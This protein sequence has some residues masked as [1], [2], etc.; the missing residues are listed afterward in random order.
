[1]LIPTLNWLTPSIFASVDNVNL[2]EKNLIIQGTRLD[3]YE[4]PLYLNYN[5]RIL[6]KNQDNNFENGVYL[7]KASFD[8]YSYFIKL[9]NQIGTTVFIQSGDQNK[10]TTWMLISDYEWFQ[11]SSSSYN[12]NLN[13]TLNE[14]LNEI[15]RK[16]EYRSI[17][18][19]WEPQLC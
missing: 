8:D 16:V 9:E 14:N 5:D 3:G 19:K 10:N 18:D 1:M 12:E 11:L 15:K 6:L 2:I 7:F 4:V 17:L 13:E